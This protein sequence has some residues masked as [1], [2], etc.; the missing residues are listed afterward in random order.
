M[1]TPLKSTLAAVA[2]AWLAL[3]S[4]GSAATVLSRAPETAVYFGQAYA[5][6]ELENPL[7]PNQTLLGYAVA[8]WRDAGYAGDTAPG[9]QDWSVSHPAEI[10]G[11]AE[12]IWLQTTGHAAM[13]ATTVAGTT[14]GILLNG[15]ANHGVAAVAVDG[16]EIARLD[17]NTP[18]P[19]PTT[20]FVLVKGLAATTHAI[21]VAHAG[22]SGLEANTIALL[23]AAVL[24]PK[25]AKWTQPPAPG[26]KSDLFLGWNEPSD[27][28][29]GYVAADDWVCTSTNPVSR[30][31]WW[32][33]YVRWNAAAPPGGLDPVQSFIVQFWTDVPA[34][35]SQPFSHPGQC[36]YHQEVR[37][38]PTFAGW[39]YDPIANSFETCFRYEADLPTTARFYQEPGPTGTNIYWISI[40]AASQLNDLNRWGWKTRPRDP[41][42]PAP[43]DAVRITSPQQPQIGAQFE[44]G[45]PLEWPAGRSWD[46]AFELISS[47]N[48]V[49][50]AE[51]YPDL[52][53]FPLAVQTSAG[54]SADPADLP[55]L[56]ADDFPC[57]VS[58]KITHVT[59]WG[60][61]IEN[62][63]PQAGLAGVPFT[64]SFHGDVPAGPGNASMPG[65][66]LWT[67]TFPPGSYSYSPAAVGLNEDWYDVN[68]PYPLANDSVCFR[69]DFD[70]PW[71]E[72][73]T[74]TG[75]RDNPVVYWLDVQAMVADE[76]CR[77]GWKASSNHWNDA[78]AWAAAV[79]PHLGLWQPVAYP[80]A[81]PLAQTP[82]D[83]AFSVSTDQE[84]FETKWKQ[85]PEPYAPTDGMQGWNEVSVH[86]GAQIVADDWI[87]TNDL[88][89]AD[90]HWWGSF[91][92]WSQEQ[93]P[94]LPDAFVLTI[95]TEAPGAP[96]EDFNHP[97]QAV[98]QVACTNYTYRFAGWDFDPRDP[99]RP[100]E[101]CFLFEQDLLPEEWFWQEPRAGGNPYWLSIAARYRQ[102]PD[103]H[104]WG[105]STRPRD[106]ASPAANDAVV[107]VSPTAPAPGVAYEAGQPIEHPEGISWDTAFVLT[108]VAGGLDFGDAPDGPYPTRLARDGARHP[109]VPGIHLGAVVDWE[110]DGQPN[111]A[112]TGDDL[113]HLPDEDGVAVVGQLLPG[114]P[115]QI[116]VTAST[117]GVLDA[118]IDFGN[119]GN[120]TDAGDRIC[121][122]VAL[123]PG[124]N[125]VHFQVPPATSAGTSVFGR[126]RFSTAGGLEFA[127]AALD[128]E[129]EDYLLP[130][131]PW[132][133][134]AGDLG[135][136]PDSSNTWGFP[137]SA[138]PAGMPPVVPGSYPTVYQAGS[139]PFGPWHQAPLAMAFLGQAV[140]REN[141]ADIGLDQDGI[142]N[143]NPAANLPDLDAADDGVPFPLVLPYCRTTAFTVWLNSVGLGLPMYLNAWFDWNRDGDWNDAMS[144]PDGT[145][146]PE[147]AVQN[148]AV[149]PM[150]AGLF[151]IGV[152]PFTSWHPSSQIQPLWMRV[153]LSETP[154]PGPLGF[155]GA[156]GD[157]PPGGYQFGETEDHYVS[158]YATDEQLDYGDAPDPTYPTR[159]ASDGARHG[160]VAGFSLGNQ[161]DAE[162]D[163]WQ[164]ANAAGDDANGA[165]DEDG[166][167]FTN[168]ILIGRASCLEVDLVA[169]PAG[170]RLDAWLD[171]NGDGDW[172]DSGEQVLAGA[173]LVPGT[174]RNLC[175]TVPWNAALGPA[176]A[177]FRLSSAGGLAPTGAARD[178]EVEDYVIVVRQSAN[179]S[180]LLAITNLV[181][182]P[183]STV[184]IQWTEAE[185]N[186]HYQL[187]ETVGLTDSA[188]QVW[189]NVGPQVIGPANAHTD[190]N[191]P[192]RKFYRVVM[193][194][195][196]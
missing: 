17:M 19:P 157:G 36:V 65:A 47:Y 107:V 23:G 34:T 146:A 130:I 66:A 78:A 1:K 29:Q 25:D 175:F 125:A 117:N 67:K 82:I 110:L 24:A 76:N 120:W 103:Q 71:P 31:R 114:Q 62:Q 148:F 3:G 37:A 108:T 30:V 91:R 26:T 54:T 112:A 100:P 116:S 121:A 191:L 27:F 61:W 6:L 142:N 178:G 2:G 131:A 9:Y 165:D 77:F 20:A 192:P 38:T 170:G 151:P 187:Q 84:V 158:A 137:M 119:D 51:Q 14:L 106:P 70:I 97:L 127:G 118:W 128:G 10:D 69:Y 42:S 86:G 171:F 94:Q 144:C 80:P 32:G 173:A 93:P 63:F 159:L 123:V 88:P 52:S 79:E 161:I 101:A 13:T 182:D 179:A 177:R 154:W 135:D 43:E 56:L 99:G 143:L 181:R 90:V 39:D 176:V 15:D 169:G 115:G 138:N 136:A 122:G 196:P 124:T 129:V 174:N 46:F 73:F 132:P 68:R 189:S 185:S 72:A 153:T 141:E 53:A 59:I 102:T 28:Y 105:W 16:V 190:T 180:G 184:T 35:P 126:F 22:G 87:C 5:A 83:L 11:T 33:S 45:V 64:L 7:A 92:A 183:A 145:P 58:G 74:Q 81:H 57:S 188:G 75:T 163:G 149:G 96:G 167:V 12:E 44:S 104:V 195:T 55:D 186:L 18:Q 8:E 89:V 4:A 41:A 164:T 150:P 95:W 48:L 172:N 162:A 133:E 155:A 166:V 113:V 152:P 40:S 139:P 21:Q 140:S 98:W 111:A 134:A 85:L 49:L 50:K 156:G 194:Y 160:I 168:Q 147:W 109:C 60:G 193:P